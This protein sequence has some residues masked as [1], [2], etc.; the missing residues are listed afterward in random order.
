[1]LLG[2]LLVAVCGYLAG[3][4]RVTTS[5]P[6][7]SPPAGARVLS[8][9]GLLIEYPLG[10]RQGGDDPLKLGLDSPV[11][12]LDGS[13]G[14]LVSGRLAT[15][16]AGP[17]PS[18]LLASLRV[19]PRTEVVNLVSTQAYRYSEV[20]LPSFHGTVDLYAVPAEAGGGRVMACFAA[21][22]LTPASQQCEKAVSSV[23]LTGPATPNLTPDPAYASALAPIVSGLQTERTRERTAMASADT[24]ATVS[25]AAASFAARATAAAHAVS[26]LEAPPVAAQAGRA[27]ASA[28]RATATAYAALGEAAATESV[29]AYDEDRTQIAT[30]ESAVD[31]ALQT[32]TL[33]GYG[34]A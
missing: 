11:A 17:L 34:R 29:G 26:S 23:T 16:E 13:A 7:E 18:R 32:F 21:R 12:L 25:S 14:G 19:L 20:S 24:V 3:S 27:L 15:G 6:A 5:A 2:L 4:H 28:L 10:W 22:S 8:N 1:M 9:A 30:A 33:L 31:R